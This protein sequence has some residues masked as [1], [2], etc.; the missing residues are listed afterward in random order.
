MT[1]AL[2][3]LTQVHS[4]ALEPHDLFLQFGDGAAP[5]FGGRAVGVRCGAAGGEQGCALL[6]L[7]GAVRAV[8]HPARSACAPCGEGLLSVLSRQQSKTEFLRSLDY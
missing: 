5:L 8:A 1:Q 2:L 3:C 4:P 6:M 7:L